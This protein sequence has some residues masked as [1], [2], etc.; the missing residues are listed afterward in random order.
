MTRA[1]EAPS[2]PFRVGFTPHPPVPAE[3]AVVWV[4]GLPVRHIF[5]PRTSASLRDR[6]RQEA[7]AQAQHR[8]R[9][10]DAG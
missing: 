10:R 3:S 6:I 9:F 1:I 8:A 5:G 4:D 7:R 2:A